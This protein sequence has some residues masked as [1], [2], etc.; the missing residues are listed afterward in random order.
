MLPGVYDVS[1]QRPRDVPW[2]L[3]SNWTPT[4]SQAL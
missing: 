3:G 4:Q 2:L 1:A